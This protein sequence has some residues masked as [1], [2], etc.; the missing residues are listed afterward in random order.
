MRFKNYKRFYLIH[1]WS[2]KAF[3]GSI[4]HWAVSCL[5]GWSIKIQSRKGLKDKNLWIWLPR[6]ERINSPVLMT[7]PNL[8][9][10]WWTKYI[11]D[12]GLE[13]SFVSHFAPFVLNDFRSFWT[14]SDIL[15]RRFS[16]SAISSRWMLGRRISSWYRLN[17]WR[18]C[19]VFAF[20]FLGYR[21]LYLSEWKIGLKY[22]SRFPSIYWEYL[23][24]SQRL[25]FNIYRS[26]SYEK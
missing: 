23:P 11:L 4:V 3:K 2:D 6:S 20:M 17:S 26:Y 8:A 14:Y 12:T 22:C 18:N 7:S 21:N 9:S 15:A 5:H 10:A 16:R 24:D 13:K 19:I 25:P 1:A